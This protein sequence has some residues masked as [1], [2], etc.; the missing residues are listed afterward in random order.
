MVLLG[1]QGDEEIT[2]DE[3]AGLLGTI[4]YEVLCGIGPRVPRVV[5]GSAPG[6]RPRLGPTARGRR[7]AVR[8]GGGPG[9][10][11]WPSSPAEASGCTRCPL[12]AGRTQVV[13]GVGDPPP[14]SCSWARPR[15]AT[16]TWPGEPF[17]GRSGKLLDRL[18]A[19]ELGIDRRR[20]YIANVVKCRPPENRDPR[21]DEI[22]ACR[23]YL[24]AQIELIAPVVV[25]TLGNFATKLLL[26]TTEGIRRV[27]GRAYPFGGGPPGPHLPPGR[28]PALGGRGGGRDAGRPGAGQAAAGRARAGAARAG[29]DR[30][31]DRGRAGRLT[32][33]PA[34]RRPGR[35]PPPWPACPSRATWC[36]WSAA[37]GP[38]RPPSP[39]ASPAGLG[40]A[41]PVTSPTFTL[42]RQYPCA[43]PADGSG[44]LVHADVYRLDALARW[45]TWAWPSWWRTAAVALVEWGDAAAPALGRRDPDGPPRRPAGDDDD[46][47]AGDTAGPRRGGLGGPVER[48]GRRPWPR[49]GRRR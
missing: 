48:P 47:A 27:R 29:A 17:V 24:D 40:V 5:A 3:W 12:A 32:G 31:D 13:F 49:G 2:A 18:M 9:R 39:R 21:P 1:R 36:C 25:V 19:E 10:P 34:P 14:T 42:V 33:P 8:C 20:C 30:G 11:I 45:R 7:R 26:D 37:S 22:A 38:A 4:S 44:Q 15:A 43:G 6:D 23:P 41:E 28:R 46:S 35:W 16:R